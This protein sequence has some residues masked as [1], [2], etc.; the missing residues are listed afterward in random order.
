VIVDGRVSPQYVEPEGSYCGQRSG[1]VFDQ[2]DRHNDDIK[3]YLRLK[4]EVFERERVEKR[5]M[6]QLFLLELLKTYSVEEKEE[7]AVMPIV[8]EAVPEFEKIVECVN[9]APVLIDSKGQI[10]SMF[11][12]ICTVDQQV[13][14]MRK[15]FRANAS[16]NFV[17]VKCDVALIGG[18]NADEV[19]LKV[20]GIC[21]KCDPRRKCSKCTDLVQCIDH[22]KQ[23]EIKVYH[24][25]NYLKFQRNLSVNLPSGPVQ[26]FSG[27][28]HYLRPFETKDDLLALSKL[29]SQKLKGLSNSHQICALDFEC[30][31]GDP[32]RVVEAGV[33]WYNSCCDNLKV[34]NYRIHGYTGFGAFSNPIYCHSIYMTY[35]EMV[36]RLKKIV[37]RFS[38]IAV[39]DRRLE[40]A[41]F[42][43][44]G[45]EKKFVDVQLVLNPLR[46]EQLRNFVPRVPQVQDYLHCASNDAYWIYLIMTRFRAKSDFRLLER[47]RL[48]AYM[49]SGCLYEDYQQ[50]F[51]RVFGCCM[52]MHVDGCDLIE[53]R[54]H[55]P[56]SGDSDLLIGDELNFHTACDFI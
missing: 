6:D 4:D 23:S 44:M 41:I 35:Q 33:V 29:D 13:C 12:Q 40:S 16:R 46:R 7:E 49:L 37:S 52:E 24:R 25:D 10:E 34:E 14:V 22:F 39:F 1:E 45:L 3:E 30:V 2:Y 53:S 20:T 54:I 51:G 43:C 11:G 36:D 56:V 5:K 27:K 26:Q 55:R 15:R 47:T 50:Y 18:F 42:D 21:R 48:S 32:S 9:E 19:Q 28:E 17:C 31:D 8:V 38:Y